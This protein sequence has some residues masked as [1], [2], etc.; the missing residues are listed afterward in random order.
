MA[1]G[2]TGG[3]TSVGSGSGIC[4]PAG[5]AAGGAQGDGEEHEPG[6]EVERVTGCS[7]LVLVR[8]SWTLT[9]RCI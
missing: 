6:V 8:L 7:F 9:Y 3:T 1:R 2:G 4:A 5:R